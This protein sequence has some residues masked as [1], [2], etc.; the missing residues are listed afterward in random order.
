MDLS[1][2]ARLVCCLLHEAFI[3]MI[4]VVLCRFYPNFLTD[5]CWML[6]KIVWG[7]IGCSIMMERQCMMKRENAYMIFVL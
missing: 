5:M 3:D 4:R 2:K 6:P 1:L 7:V